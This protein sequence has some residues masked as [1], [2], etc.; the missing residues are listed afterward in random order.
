MRVLLTRPVDDARDTAEALQA[1]GHEAVIEPMLRIEVGAGPAVDTAPYRLLVITSMNGA[2]AARQRLADRDVPVLAV[3]KATAREARRSGFNTVI[4][5]D[6]N[7]TQGI[8]SALSRMDGSDP[9]P[10]LHVSGAETAGDLQSAVQRLGLRLERI[11]LYTAKAAEGL[12]AAA[13]GAIAAQTL[14]AAMFFSP[15]TASIFCDL[16]KRARLDPFLARVGACAISTNT[17][18]SLSAI[19]FRK[20]LVAKDTSVQAML[21]LLQLM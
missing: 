1:L 2:R 19:T 15:R 4:C 9:R 13:T 12:S 3:G 11:Q 18:T 20:V 10:L 21:D 8:L 6:G 14:D 7:G 16:A 17:A 5:A